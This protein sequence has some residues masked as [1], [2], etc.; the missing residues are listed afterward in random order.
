MK[1]LHHNIPERYIGLFVINKDIIL[2]NPLKAITEPDFLKGLS[3]LYKENTEFQ[4]YITALSYQINPDNAL[5][6]IYHKQL[7]DCLVNRDIDRL[8]EISKTNIFNKILPPVILE[9]ENYN[10]PIITLNGL[11]NDAVISEHEKQNIWDDIYL[12]TK[13]QKIESLELTNSQKILLVQISKKS[14]K[15][16]AEYL[17]NSLY[18]VPIFDAL[19]Y[20]Q[21]IDELINIDNQESLNIDILKLLKTKLVSIENFISIV[22]T[23]QQQYAKYKIS[24]GEPELN[25]YLS[26]LD[27]N[28]L[29]D[30]D[31]IQYLVPQ[32]KFTL[33]ISSIKEKITTNKRDKANLPILFNPLKLIYASR[34]P[35]GI[36]LEDSDIYSMFANSTE[37]EDFY[38]DL[39]AMR[40]ARDTEFNQSYQSYF[41]SV[42]DTPSEIVKNKVSERIEYYITFKDILLRSVSFPNILIKQVV[43]NIIYNI[44]PNQKTNIKSLILSFENICEI[45][46]IDKHDFIE[47]LNRW[48]TIEFDKTFIKSIP[49]SYFEEAIKNSSDLTK[50]SILALNDYFNKLTKDEWIAIFKDI[51]SDDYKRLIIISYKEWNSFSLEALKDVLLDISKTK[52][53]ENKDEILKI[54]TSFEENDKDLTNTFKNIRDE[55]IINRNIN[56]DLFSF[57]AQWLFKYAHLN[58]KSGDVL[59]TIFISTLLDNDICLSIIIQNKDII[60]VLFDDS[61]PNEASDF[62][63]ALRDRFQKDE[64]KELAK[65]LGVKK[66]KTKEEEQN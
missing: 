50:Q 8:N 53:I 40:L 51:E 43:S 33:F 54:I 15:L 44:R 22:K 47:S 5:E 55:F 64:I 23:K 65:F 58:E 36:L 46:Q 4:K 17:I 10:E 20:A 56:V 24:I 30:I 11:T 2:E 42:L 28:Q 29:N 41:S 6:I 57:F 62:K 38:F 16:W 60:K 35:L 9:I 14:K 19:K 61:S 31:Y 3:Y 27:I 7:K 25:N 18:E 32:F 21:I 49:N 13:Q 66:R 34:E 39:I 45:N 52:T 1:L 48:G 26:E 12:K 63:E 37:N 59:R